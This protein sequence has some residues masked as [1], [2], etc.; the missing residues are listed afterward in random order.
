MGR[1]NSYLSAAVTRPPTGR[2]RSGQRDGLRPLG[3][4]PTT[5]RP[6]PIRDADLFDLPHDSQPP[7]FSWADDVEPNAE[8]EE[9]E[10][11][12][13]PTIAR[14]EPLAGRQHRVPILIKDMT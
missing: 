5:R 12:F 4:P 9:G 2:G 13:V 11:P 3:R 7:G 6:L 8:P 14:R 10:I 1:H